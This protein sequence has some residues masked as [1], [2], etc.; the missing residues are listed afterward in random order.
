[1]THLSNASPGERI[2]HVA[3][4]L[5][6]HFADFV[7]LWKGVLDGWEGEAEVEDE[8]KGEVL[9]LRYIDHLTSSQ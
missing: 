7:H 4:V 1:M 3:D 5:P 8:V 9:V 6:W 2:D